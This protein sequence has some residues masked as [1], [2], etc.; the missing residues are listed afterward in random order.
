MNVW[1]IYRTPHSLHVPGEKSQQLLSR[2]S[3]LG[4]VVVDLLQGRS[5]LLCPL[6][7]FV[8]SGNLNFRPFNPSQCYCLK[9]LSTIFQLYRGGQFYW[10][11]KPEDPE[12]ATNMSQVC[13]VHLVLI[14]IKIHNISG[15]RHSS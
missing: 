15:D 14:E 10:C 2:N 8:P 4:V 5:L 3:L 12:K 13:D 11:R 7:P 9:P 1:C 6:S